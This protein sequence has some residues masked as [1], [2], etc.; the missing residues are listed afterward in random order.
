MQIPVY[1]KGLIPRD[2]RHMLSKGGWVHASPENFEFSL[3]ELQQNLKACTLQ[4]AKWHRFKVA[5]LPSP[6]R[7]IYSVNGVLEL[8]YF[9][10][11]CFNLQL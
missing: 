7:Y 4:K 10:Y 1:H 2:W 5:P 3:T 6:K 11:Q 9:L 8:T